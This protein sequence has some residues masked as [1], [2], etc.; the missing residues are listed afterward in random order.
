MDRTTGHRNDGHHHAHVS[1]L[2]D[3]ER[4]KSTME[5]NDCV[6]PIETGSGIAMRSIRWVMSVRLITPGIDR[7]SDGF[8]LDASSHLYERV[9]PSV[10]PKLRISCGEMI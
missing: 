1:Q 4:G 8:I 7:A 10:G 6:A 5:K 2:R 9:C 3:K